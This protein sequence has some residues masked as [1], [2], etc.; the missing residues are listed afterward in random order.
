LCLF[1]PSR[2]RA[3]T[4]QASAFFRLP[5]RQLLGGLLVLRLLTFLFAQSAG[6]LLNLGGRSRPI[7][8][9]LDV[10]RSGLAASIDPLDDLC[11]ERLSLLGSWHSLPLSRPAGQH[12]VQQLDALL[13]RSTYCG[14]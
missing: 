8:L 7:E 3:G 6:A 14:L 1:L 10:R 13:E 5:L 4:F 12:L 11:A 2:S 9:P